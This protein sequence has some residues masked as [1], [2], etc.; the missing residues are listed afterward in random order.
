VLVEILESVLVAHFREISSN[1]RLEEH[2]PK[3]KAAVAQN[4]HK[5]TIDQKIHTV[6]LLL[7]K[8]VV[9]KRIFNFLNILDWQCVK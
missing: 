3:Q 8:N 2:L 1:K 9:I 4:A 7:V 5:T 6:D